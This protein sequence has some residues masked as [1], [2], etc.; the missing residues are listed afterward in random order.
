MGC[1][2]CEHVNRPKSSAQSADTVPLPKDDMLDHSKTML[3][4]M[5]GQF[6][7][8]STAVRLAVAGKVIGLPANL[9]AALVVLEGEGKGRR[10]TLEKDQIVLGRKQADVALTDPEASRRH[11]MLLLYEDF[12]VVKDLGS[13]NG[14]QVNG[15]I[16]KEGLL[17]SGGRIQIGTTVFQLMLSP[18]TV[19]SSS[20]P[21]RNA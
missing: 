4:P 6:A 21:K 11:C 3:G 2:Y 12:S 9:E 10:I 20:P 18:K 1:P 5:D 15:R 14:T 13:A 19:Q 7:D 17:K 8:E 16:V